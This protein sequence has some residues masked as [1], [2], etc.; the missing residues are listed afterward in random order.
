MSKQMAIPFSLDA[1]GGVAVVS[2]PVESLAQR[3]RALVATLPGQRAM[4]ANFGVATTSVMFDFDPSIG[5]MELQQMVQEA[6][7]LWEPA[8]QVISVNPVLS[9]DGSEVLGVNVDISAG[10]PVSTGVS[11]QYPVVITATGDVVRSG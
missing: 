10:D 9:A 6:V 1:S 5:T 8:A 11:P 2:D 4:R 3:V 7:R